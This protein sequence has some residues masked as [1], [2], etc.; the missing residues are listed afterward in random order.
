MRVRHRRWWV[1]WL[2]LGLGLLLAGC[3]G[4]G[5]PG[6]GEIGQLGPSGGWLDGPDGLAVSMAAGGLDRTVTLFLTPT[7]TP[8]LPLPSGMQAVSGAYRLSASE[9]APTAEPFVL[10]VP[11]PKGVDPATLVLAVYHPGGVPHVPKPMWFR[12]T[13]QVA[14]SLGAFL[15]PVASVPKDGLVFLLATDTATELPAPAGE[16]LSPSGLLGQRWLSQG[17]AIVTPKNAFNSASVTAFQNAFNQVLGLY[18]KS[19]LRPPVMQTVGAKAIVQGKGKP[20]KMDYSQA[21]YGFY[22]MPQGVGEC[23]PGTLGYYEPA[24]HILVV[25]APKDGSMSALMR[26]TLVHELFHA[27]QERYGKS[28]L[29]WA[30]STAALAENSIQDPAYKPQLT[31]DYSAREDRRALAA[32]GSGVHYRTQDFWYHVLREK[33]LAFDAAMDAY[34]KKGMNLAGTDAA[35]GGLADEYWHWFKDQTYVKG[36]HTARPATACRPD[37]NTVKKVVSVSGVIGKEVW[38][39]HDYSRKALNGSV[40]T[41]FLPSHRFFP[42]TWR[43]WF[44]LSDNSALR[45][46]DR[47]TVDRGSFACNFQKPPVEITVAPG[48]SFQSGALAANV[49]LGVAKDDAEPLANPHRKFRLHVKSLIGKVVFPIPPAP[50]GGLDVMVMDE[51]SCGGGGGTCYSGSYL[52]TTTGSAYE[53]LL[54]VGE[55]YFYVSGTGYTKEYSFVKVPE[56]GTVTLK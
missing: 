1:L 3:S 38:K 56:D 16:G 33:G 19:K 34:M 45:S 54:P 30:E 31:P 29:W 4:G 41:F 10:V 7:T 48:Q 24:T 26:R 40:F 5:G 22:M 23:D 50:T 52:L 28:V 35:I 39:D 37:A 51:K 20:I 44:T 21:K 53:L 11:I 47:A 8:S 12:L 32:F 17:R 13:G 18:A 36:P 15:V 46:T 43:I 9:D 2:G 55:Y 49:D 14:A 25:C 27:V 42:I 6:P